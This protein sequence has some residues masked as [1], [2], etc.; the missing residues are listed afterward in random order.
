[1]VVFADGMQIG[2]RAGAEYNMQRRR[3]FTMFLRPGVVLYKLCFMYN[4]HSSVAYKSLQ[5]KSLAAWLS[6]RWAR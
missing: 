1:M 3:R 2:A 5:G 4:R 6:D